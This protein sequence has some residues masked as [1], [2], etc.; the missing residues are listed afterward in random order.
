MVASAS[1]DSN[2]GL[3]HID[4]MNCFKVLENFPDRFKVPNELKVSDL[5]DGISNIIS[6]NVLLTQ[7]ERPCYTKQEIK[8]GS[9][10]NFI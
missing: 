6:R 8:K 2:D 9:A 7:S 3:Y 10:R 4:D 5:I 1:I